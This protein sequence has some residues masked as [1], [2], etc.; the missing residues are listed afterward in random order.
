MEGLHCG[1]A[2]VPDS[3]NILSPNA[4]LTDLKAKWRNESTSYLKRKSNFF[5]I[6]L[7]NWQQCLKVRQLT[8]NY[9]LKTTNETTSKMTKLFSSLRIKS[10]AN[11]FVQLDKRCAIWALNDIDRWLVISWK[12]TE[13][14][15]QIVAALLLVNRGEPQCAQMAHVT[16][17]THI[18]AL[19]QAP[20]GKEF[21]DI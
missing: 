1:S 13:T 5:W 20:I 10:S 17:T 9:L 7:I 16:Y 18:Q 12:H 11:K 14:S 8:G 19:N 3:K 2:Y 21:I 4:R 15:L 6:W